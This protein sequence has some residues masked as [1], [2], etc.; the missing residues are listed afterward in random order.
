LAPIVVLLVDDDPDDRLLTREYLETIDRTAYQLT[1]VATY[2]AALEAM[3]SGDFDVCLVDYYLGAFDGLELLR[4]AYAR[5]CTAPVILLTGS[6]DRRIDETAMRMGAAD[7]LVKDQ[8]TS[9]LLAR[10]IGHAI[11][12][13]RTLKALRESEER[14]RLLVDGV[15]DHALFLLTETGHIASWNAGAERMTG[16]TEA[17]IVGEHVSQFHIPQDRERRSPSALLQAA[18][19][20]GP[21]HDEGWRVRKDGSC[22]WAEATVTVLLNEDGHVRGYAKVLRD[23]TDRRRADQ[24]RTALVREQAARGL[25]EAATHARDQFLAIAAH[26]L[27]TPLTS[28]LAPIQLLLRLLEEDTPLDVAHFHQRLAR[29]DGQ[30]RK[31]ARLIDRM[32]DFSRAQ[33]GRLALQRETVDPTRLVAE[34]VEMAGFQS[35]NHRVSL[36]APTIFLAVVDPL[37]VDQ[38]LTNLL[39]NAIKYSP[40]GGQIEVELTRSGPQVAQ[41]TV[42]DHGLG[43]PADA[44]SHVFEQFFRAHEIDHRSG[45]GI[46]LY[47]SHL[48]VERHGGEITVECPPDG[49]TRFVVVLPIDGTSLI[50]SSRSAAGPR[51]SLPLSPG[52]SN[53]VVYQS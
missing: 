43:I 20:G 50:S 31:M 23:I 39:D 10:T 8:I 21:S 16:Y 42:R 28:I 45:M 7:Y 3:T 9:P 44:R 33:T 27:K 5:G 29:I 36:H 47:I 4:E 15:S 18:R 19:L 40:L 49:G 35:D 25:A 37:R 46:G 13:G 17:E 12:R 38:L 6:G 24:E 22:F 34:A 53:A 41:L 26:E 1:E 51:A 14:F 32:L 30:T 52:G 11:E 2:D 48:I